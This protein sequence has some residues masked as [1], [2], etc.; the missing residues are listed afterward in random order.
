MKITKQRLK[1]IIRNELNEAQSYVR[2]ED[3][4]DKVLLPALQAA[5]I[6]EWDLGVVLQDAAN[7]HAR[8]RRGR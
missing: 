6:E 8:R 1:E 7:L 4:L 3:L 2:T 5:G